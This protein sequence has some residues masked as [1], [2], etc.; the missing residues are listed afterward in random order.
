MPKSRL[1]ELY[2]H[3]PIRQAQEQVYF[4]FSATWALSVLEVY[5]SEQDL[6]QTLKFAAKKMSVKSDFWLGS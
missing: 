3:S 2:L 6:P 1:V 5:L 4:Y